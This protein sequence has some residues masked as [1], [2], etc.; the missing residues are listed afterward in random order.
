MKR[1]F[2]LLIFISSG[3]IAQV[4]K[5]TLQESIDI[6]L[7]NSKD[8]KISRAKQVSADAKITETTSQML[9]QLKFLAGYT[10]LSEVDPFSITLPF[11]VNGRSLDPIPISLSIVN[12][13]TSK[14]SLQ[15]PL[16]TG[17]RLI[18]LRSAAK[19]NSTAA[20]E[21]YDKDVN[22]AS[23]KIQ[24]S[25][26]QF[27]KAQQLLNLL[28]ENL[29]QL[30]MHQEDTK[31]FLEN[32]LVTENDL[33]KIEVQVS[34]TQLQQIEA[35]N[36]LD[37][38]RMA[39]NQ[40]LGL[41]LNAK[42]EIDVKEIV[43]EVKSYSFESLLNEAKEK[44]RDLIAMQYRDKASDKLISASR[45]GWFPQVFLSSNYY[46][47]RPNQRVFPPQDKF[48]NTWDVGVTLSWDVWNWNY[49]SSQTIQ[50]EQTKI[51]TE[52]AL[53]QLT[54]AVELE[55]YQNFLTYQRSKE[56][57]D[58]SNKA[59]KQARENYRTLKDKYNVQLATSTD[60]IDAETLVLQA[61]TNYNN[62][63]VDYE[64]A[65]VRLEKSVGRKIW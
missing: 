46:Y 20:N 5:L 40:A 2:L 52:T 26:W 23:F 18:S 4:Q 21:E 12:N 34:N 64:I 56:K 45:S 55:V 59:L 48:K 3:L 15:Q 63:L 61:E 28:D 39:F 1:I 35:Q 8:L 38:S 62:A 43:P 33:L 57:I 44:R 54:D 27:Y 19:L 60:L 29:N 31:N 10:R 11:Q 47:S 14:L 6:G 32:G 13:Y 22:E 58:V 53:S 9:P 16:F 41:N 65:E 37:I 7:K 36:T 17:L 51:Q 25:F 49:T 24:S 30:K 42:T 50:A